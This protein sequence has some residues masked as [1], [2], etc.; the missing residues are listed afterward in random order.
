MQ[1]CKNCGAA[2]R[3]IAT[4]AGTAVIC[5]NEKIIF[6]TE[7]G[8]KTSG[9]LIHNCNKKEAKDGKKEDW[10]TAGKKGTA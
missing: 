5:D 10:K 6:V 1:I 8:R 9:Y 2:I 3:Y 4:S 7:N